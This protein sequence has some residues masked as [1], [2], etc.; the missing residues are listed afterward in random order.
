MILYE[1]VCQTC[2]WRD[3]RVCPMAERHVQVCRCGATLTKLL[4]APT[5]VSDT[6]DEWNENVDVNPVHYTSRAERRRDLKARGLV[7]FTRHVGE[8]GSDRSK[9]TSRWV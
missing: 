8:Q 4:A 6:I 3:E 5:T 2:G 7:E 1:F 9:H